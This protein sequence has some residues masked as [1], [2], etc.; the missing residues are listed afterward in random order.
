MLKLAGFS[1]SATMEFAKPPLSYAD[2]AALLIERGLV[3]SD[4]NVLMRQLEAVGYYRLCAYCGTGEMKRTPHHFA[5]AYSRRRDGDRDGGESFSRCHFH[6]GPDILKRVLYG[7]SCRNYEAAAES[8]PGAIGLSSST[9]SRSFIQ[10]SA[11]T[12]RAF[13][14]RDL[15]GEDVVA[16]FLDGKAFADS[17]M[18]IAL[19]LTMSGEKRFLGFVETDTENAKVLT[20]F[21]R[22]LVD[23]GLDA[24]HGLLV[25]LSTG[26]RAFG[27]Q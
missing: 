24:S 8:V 9:V 3:V 14:E 17:T 26:A 12:L 18:A 22:S 4:P 1:F 13:Q 11:A 5:S 16:L 10:A 19:G 2:Q 6:I 15:A 23:R 7:I 27:R 25:V 21:L 20:P